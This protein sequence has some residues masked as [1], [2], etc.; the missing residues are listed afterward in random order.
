MFDAESVNQFSQ[1]KKSGIEYVQGKLQ[2]NCW[3][4]RDAICIAEGN[5]KQ[6]ASFDYTV[7]LSY[8]MQYRII[9]KL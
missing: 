7:K 5:S 1:A 6:T 4:S 8:C 2:D 3:L 9:L